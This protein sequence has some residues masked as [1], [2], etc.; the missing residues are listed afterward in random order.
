MDQLIENAKKLLTDWKD[1]AYT[2]GRGVLPKIG[3]LA[4][5]H[6]R[7]ALVVCNTTYM[8]P[9]A[10]AVAASLEQAGV[11]MAGGRIAPDA[12]PNAPRAD[13][14]RLET[15]ILHYKPDCIIAVG[16]GST[17][18]ACKAANLLAA[19]GAARTP[20]GPGTETTRSE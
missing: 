18:D 1:D 6:G 13:V 7:T 4:A 17:I 10:D 3:A 8:K 9:V 12:G 5:K 2:F 15:Y 19:L 11:K 16:G 14:Y 20:A